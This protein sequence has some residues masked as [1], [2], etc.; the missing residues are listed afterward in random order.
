MFYP[1]P[2]INNQV[3]VYLNRNQLEEKLTIIGKQLGGVFIKEDQFKFVRYMSGSNAYIV[4]GKIEKVRDAFLLT[5]EIRNFD[6]I[7]YLFWIG[8]PLNLLLPLLFTDG[9][10]YFLN[11][12]FPTAEIP[13]IVS[14]FVNVV[15]L[16]LGMSIL[17]YF[18]KSDMQEYDNLLKELK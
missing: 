10:F 11:H 1:L 2:Q 18:I 5:Y 7:K 9:S 17:N 4:K 6:L 13:T 12:W 15:I 8:I 14:Y 16:V 3:K